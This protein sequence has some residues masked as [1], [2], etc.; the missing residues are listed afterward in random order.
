MATP[1]G[2]PTLL[3]ELLI[4]LVDNALNYARPGVPPR[5]CISAI[6]LGDAVKVSVSDN[7]IGIPA[8]QRER[9]FEVFTRL[10]GTDAEKGTGIGLAI[11]RKAARSMGSEVTVESE[12]GE[13]T[14]FSVLLPC[15]DEGP[16]ET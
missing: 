5:V 14:S 4:N 3:E 9:I 1:I 12:V 13:G 10:P 15:A 6:C 7:G 16:A 2:D 11:V 8:D